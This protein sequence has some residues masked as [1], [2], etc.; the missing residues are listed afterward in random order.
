M[1]SIVSPMDKSSLV[2]YRTSFL[3][4]FQDEN[5]RAC[6]PT[7]YTDAEFDNKDL[8]YVFVTHSGFSRSPC[9]V[10]SFTLRFTLQFYLIVYLADL[11]YGFTLQFYLIVLPHSFKLQF[12]R[13]KNLQYLAP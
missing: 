2:M 1:H 3:F 7:S 8:E 9:T 12:C 4:V 13:T 11:P 5:I 6:L 10:F